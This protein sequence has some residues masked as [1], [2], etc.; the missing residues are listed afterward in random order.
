MTNGASASGIASE[1]SDVRSELAHLLAEEFNQAGI[2]CTVTSEAIV[3]E[4]NDTFLM[5]AQIVVPLDEDAAGRTPEALVYFLPVLENP[6][7][8]QYMVFLD[9]EVVD[10]AG[11]DLARFVALV[12]SRLTLTG[13]E[14]SETFG[15]VVFRHTHAVDA[16]RI[17]PGVIAWPLSVI[18]ENVDTYGPLVERVANGHGLG[19]A[20]AALA[21]VV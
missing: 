7:V 2:G 6:P 13:F 15:Q 18:R 12:N 17:D 8:V 14:M 10:A 1:P 5:P 21:T 19:E 9:Y 3:R 11:A 20:V 4:G 16:S